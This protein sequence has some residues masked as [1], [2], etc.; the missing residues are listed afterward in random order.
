MQI[1]KYTTEEEAQQIIDEKIAQGFVLVE[2][3][4]ITE[5][6][7]LGFKEPSEINSSNNIPL[8]QQIAE[9]KEQN[10]ILMDAIATLYETI[11][12]GTV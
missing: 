6:N 5:G 1:V 8:E 3:A 12:G 10:L 11:L 7:F 9:L 2:V 4:N